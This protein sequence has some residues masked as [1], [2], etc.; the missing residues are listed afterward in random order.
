MTA[1]ISF[2]FAGNEWKLQEQTNYHVTVSPEGS[3]ADFF[4]KWDCLPKAR[5]AAAALAV[6]CN[7]ELL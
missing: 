2:I 4:C 5:F 1:D 7:G 6:T 3:E